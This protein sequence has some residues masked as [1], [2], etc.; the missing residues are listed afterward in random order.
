MK[1][2]EDTLNFHSE[3]PRLA[4]AVARQ[5]CRLPLVLT[6]IARAMACKKTPQEWKYAIEVLQSSASKFPGMGDKAF[7]LLKYSKYSYDCLPTVGAVGLD[8]GPLTSR[9]LSTGCHD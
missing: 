5:C 3:I 1:H 8:P 4:Q 6:T 2:G 7:P 9:P